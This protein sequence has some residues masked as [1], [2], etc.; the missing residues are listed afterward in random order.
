[1]KVSVVSDPIYRN[2]AKMPRSIGDGIIDDVTMLN[3]T[4]SNLSPKR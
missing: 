2:I 3:A 1:M 4:N